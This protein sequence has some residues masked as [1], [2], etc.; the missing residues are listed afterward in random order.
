MP[1][2]KAIL[3]YGKAVFCFHVLCQCN[4]QSELDFMERAYA[5]LLNTFSPNGYNLKA[6]SGRGVCSLIVREKIRTA[7]T[8]KVVSIA[9]RRRLS[10]SHRGLHQSKSTKQKLSRHFK[11]RRGTV[12][13][14]QRSVEASAKTYTLISPN[15]TPMVVTNMAKFCR[16]NGLSK[17]RMCEVVRGRRM[18]YRGW[19]NQ[20]MIFKV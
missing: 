20:S 11:G 7:N 16:E 5:V 4:T 12:Y 8:G 10:E 17:H 6:G 3:K 19:K 13:C 18:V 1:I 14:Y 2:S 9:T 15:D